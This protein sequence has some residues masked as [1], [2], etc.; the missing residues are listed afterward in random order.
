MTLGFWVFSWPAQGL[1]VGPRLT[2]DEGTFKSS[3]VREVV[4]RVRSVT[5]HKPINR[6][7]VLA[8][9]GVK[10]GQL[11]ITVLR[12]LGQTIQDGH[13]AWQEVG[14]EIVPRPPQRG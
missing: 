13:S 6:S 3:V 5:I 14:Y 2:K 12:R 9:F 1:R 11:G 10:L 4:H 7:S 8:Y